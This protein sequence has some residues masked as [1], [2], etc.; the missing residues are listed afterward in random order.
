MNCPSLPTHDALKENCHG[1]A[2][3]F[4]IKECIIPCKVFLCTIQQLSLDKAHILKMLTV[5][6]KTTGDNTNPHTKFLSF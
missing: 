5:S 6:C 2:A 1:K 3:N 4:L